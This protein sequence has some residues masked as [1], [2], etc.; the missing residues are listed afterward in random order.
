M[1]AAIGLAILALALIGL[2]RVVLVVGRTLARAASAVAIAW[3]TE[4]GRSACER[5][6]QRRARQ[7]RSQYGASGVHY[8][9]VRATPGGVL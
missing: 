2:V 9:H 7:L 5:A 3:R 4:R 1:N 6:W 8:E